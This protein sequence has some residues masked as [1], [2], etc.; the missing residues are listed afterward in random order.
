MWWTVQ[1]WNN[2]KKMLIFNIFSVHFLLEEMK[3][4]CLISSFSFIFCLSYE[5]NHNLKFLFVFLVP[6]D[7]Q[8]SECSSGL[9][10]MDYP[11]FR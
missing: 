5:N 8:N 4:H 1:I 3:S 10:T 7:L 6:A 2:E 9:S 11:E